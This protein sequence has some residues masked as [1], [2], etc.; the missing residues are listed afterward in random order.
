MRLHMGN[1]VFICPQRSCFVNSGCGA[2]MRRSNG[3]GFQRLQSATPFWAHIR[4]ANLAEFG[5]KQISAV[6]NFLQR[7]NVGAIRFDC[8]CW[9]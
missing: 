1:S 8:Q 5:V 2:P 4:S 7:I 9:Q 3:V 6:K